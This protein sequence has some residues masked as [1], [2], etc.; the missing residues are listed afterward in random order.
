MQDESPIQGLQK[1][2][3]TSEMMYWLSLML[4]LVGI[5]WA[6]YKLSPAF[7][8]FCIIYAISH[9]IYSHPFTRLKALAVTS[10]LY[11][12]FLNGYCNVVASYM[13][14]TENITALNQV[15][16][17]VHAAAIIYFVYSIGSWPVSQIYQH[18]ED[19]KNGDNSL[20]IQLGIRGTLL[21]AWVFI[22]AG[23]LCQIAYFFAFFE[24][25]TELSASFM[26]V[27]FPLTLYTMIWTKDVFEDPNNANY[28]R[29][30][31]WQF[32][33]TTTGHILYL[34]MILYRLQNPKHFIRSH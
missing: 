34:G 7:F 9:R 26:L 19:K 18:E 3:P 21:F 11:W 2:P 14:A 12:N 1:P 13:G 24:I 22:S 27:S 6:Y 33:S 16:A 32:I 31:K 4:D 23:A 30:D 15:P 8:I 20:S 29:T 10:T 25:P 28:E 5:F 17:Q